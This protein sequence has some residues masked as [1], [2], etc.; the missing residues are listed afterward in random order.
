MEG[1]P[2]QIINRQL[3]M[4]V[5]IAELDLQVEVLL[6]EVQLF[7]VFLGKA[8]LGTWLQQLKDECY[9]K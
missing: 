4:P 7:A 3:Y 9:N 8:D 1:Y 2:G 6:D 5:R